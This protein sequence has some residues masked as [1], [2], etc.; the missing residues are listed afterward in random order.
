MFMQIFIVIFP[1]FLSVKELA[2]DFKGNMAVVASTFI[3]NIK[4]IYPFDSMLAL[5]SQSSIS[6]L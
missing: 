2:N 1:L 6:C 5:T 4:G 3:E